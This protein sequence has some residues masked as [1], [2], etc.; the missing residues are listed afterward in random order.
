MSQELTLQ[1]ERTVLWLLAF[2]QFTVIMDFMVMMPLAPQLMQAF[3]ISAAQVSGAVSAYAWCAGLSG[4]LAATYADRFDRKTLMLVVFMLFNLSNLACA[5]APNFHVLVLSRA[6]AGMTGGVLGAIS[7]SIIADLIP[8]ER[9]GAATGIVMTSF[10]MAAIAG[11]PAGVMLGAHFGWQS[12]FYLL[13]VLSML[14]WFIAARAL[15]SM[16]Q[17]LARA[18][19]PLARV[20]PELFGLF[21]VGAHLRGFLLCFAVTV[22]GMMVIPFISPMLVGNL[23]IAPAQISYVYLCGGIA[24]LFSSRLIGGWSDKLGKQRVFR[25]VALFSIAPTLFMTHMPQIPLLA[26][27]LFFPFFMVAMSGRFVPMQALLTTIPEPQRRGA[28]L[29]ANAAVQQMGTGVGAFAGGLLVHTDASGRLVGYDTIGLIAAAL[30]AFAV[31][32]IG[33]VQPA[34][35]AAVTRSPA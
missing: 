11:V 2:I 35:A 28:F 9:R 32:W 13:V 15:P 6:F 21:T 30:M 25:W 20:L 14:V 12:P 26:V 29:S 16:T 23:G 19:V 17:H 4:L 5:L 22:S 33:R 8:A 10:S 18:A 27:L 7:M 1:R 34:P 3:S 24:T 31:W